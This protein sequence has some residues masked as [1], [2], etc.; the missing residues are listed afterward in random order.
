MHILFVTC[1][2]CDRVVVFIY[3]DTVDIQWV[4]KIAY[5]PLESFI[6]ILPN[7]KRLKFIKKIKEVTQGEGITTL[8][9]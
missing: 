1:S 9:Q 2:D 7:E 6:T 8:T 4:R 5:F 3:F